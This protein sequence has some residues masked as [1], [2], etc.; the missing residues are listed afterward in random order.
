[1]CLY[2]KRKTSKLQ[3]K[4]YRNTIVYTKNKTTFPLKQKKERKERRRKKR[5]W[6]WKQDVLFSFS[7]WGG[8]FGHPVSIWVAERISPFKDTSLFYLKWCDLYQIAI[9]LFK[10]NQSCISK[11]LNFVFYHTFYLFVSKI[12]TM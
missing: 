7:L 10:G 5:E 3:L 11:R 4:F 6:K 2:C 8:Q 9:W 1:M 12:K